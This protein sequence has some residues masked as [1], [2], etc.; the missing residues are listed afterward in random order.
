L[1]RNLQSGIFHRYC[2]AEVDASISPEG[3][4][5]SV[6]EHSLLVYP[7]DD[8]SHFGAA[9]G[10]TGCLGV[11][12]HINDLVNLLSRQN[13]GMFPYPENIFLGLEILPMFT[14]C[15]LVNTE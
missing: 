7:V 4:V 5:E 11:E 10:P 6:Q 13:S 2:G 3:L 1:F 14:N 15:A 8:S 12:N 9:E